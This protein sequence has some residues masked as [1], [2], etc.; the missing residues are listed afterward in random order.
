MN[1][2]ARRIFIS[3]LL[4]S[5]SPIFTI[6]ESVSLEMSVKNQAVQMLL[7]MLFLSLT[8]LVPLVPRTV[9]NDIRFFQSFDDF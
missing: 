3:C 8:D 5:A 4:R 1:C 7:L 6:L 9:F 2:P